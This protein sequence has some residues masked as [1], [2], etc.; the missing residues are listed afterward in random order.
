VVDDI[1]LGAYVDG[2]L[3]PTVMARL[4]SILS[5]TVAVRAARTLLQPQSDRTDTPD[6]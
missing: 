5:I 4:I 2:E 1:L 3:D 6:R